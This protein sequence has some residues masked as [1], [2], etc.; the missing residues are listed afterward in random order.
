MRY[1]VDV[2]TGLNLIVQCQ[3]IH[4]LVGIETMASWFYHAPFQTRI[5][6]FVYDHQSGTPRVCRKTITRLTRYHRWVE[7]CEELLHSLLP[8]CLADVV[9][10][11]F[12][13]RCC[14]DDHARE[15]FDSCG[16]YCEVAG[17]CQFDRESTPFEVRVELVEA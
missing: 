14:Q 1:V 3:T 9:A 5:V 12:R 8:A 10:D 6:G 7:G 2:M 16:T 11:F 17:D 4:F 13:G 15:A